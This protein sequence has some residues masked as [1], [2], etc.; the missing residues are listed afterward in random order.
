VLRVCSVCGVGCMVDYGC[1]IAYCILYIVYCVLCVGCCECV[2]NVLA[3]FYPQKKADNAT[4]TQTAHARMACSGVANHSTIR[5]IHNV[6][7]QLT[8]RITTH[9]VSSPFPQVRVI[10]TSREIVGFSNRNVESKS[11]CSFS[12]YFFLGL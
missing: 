9:A 12:C 8:H 11:V 6:T 4:L 2:A 7:L 10:L 3:Q 5:T 1:C